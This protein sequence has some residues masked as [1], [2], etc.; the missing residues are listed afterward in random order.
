[1]K[2]TLVAIACAGALATCGPTVDVASRLNVQVL[3]TGWRTA[4]PVAGKNKLVPSASVKVTNVSGT[5]LPAVQVNAVFRRVGEGAEWGSAFVNA[6]GSSGMTPGGEATLT[7]SSERGYTGEDAQELMLR[8]RQFVDVT[9]D[10]F[11]KYGASQWTRLGAFPVARM[12][13][14]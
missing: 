10:V 4:G 13:L 9:V 11:A 3:T 14:P 6:A 1:M 7:L 2:R 12:L 8:N 5:T